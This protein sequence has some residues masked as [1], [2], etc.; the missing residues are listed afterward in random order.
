MSTI[1]PPYD[2]N[3]VQL[4]KHDTVKN[5]VRVFVSSNEGGRYSI[6]RQALKDLLEATNM[7]DVYLRE[8][9]PPSS[10]GI[11]EE[12][13]QELRDRDIII[14]LIDNKDGCPD[15]GGVIKEIQEA[16][17]INKKCLYVF[18][19]EDE[20]TP[21]QI[22]KELSSNTSNPMYVV[23]DKFSKM[24]NVAYEGIIND[25]AKRYRAYCYKEPTTIE[26]LQS[27]LQN[28]NLIVSTIETS[29]GDSTD[30]PILQPSTYS[31]PKYDSKTYKL[32]RREFIKVFGWDNGDWSNDHYDKT[33][34]LFGQPNKSSNL[35]EICAKIFRAVICKEKADDALF[36]LMEEEILKL[37]DSSLH[38][39]LKFRIG[40]IQN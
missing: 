24:A 22:Q 12:Y 16:K 15:N 4:M 17:R 9:S 36:N 26:G 33:A 19:K 34:K 3:E 38:E 27:S 13:L 6:V 1:F 28:T 7:T 20:Q 30:N 8:D 40:V 35:D 32:L 31:Q 23:V 10:Q 11:E 2:Y 21:T 25:I 5:K 18:C 37:H 39:I 14:F 29:R